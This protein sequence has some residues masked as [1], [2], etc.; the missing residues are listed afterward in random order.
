MS[1]ILARHA[2]FA[3]PNGR[4]VCRPVLTGVGMGGP[5]QALPVVSCL[6]PR[7]RCGI[8]CQSRANTGL[9]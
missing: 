6:R 7:G 9:H 5:H 3:L 1:F 8:I 2:T 4:R